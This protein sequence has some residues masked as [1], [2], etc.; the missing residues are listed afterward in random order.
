METCATHP[1]PKNDFSRA[2]V[3]SMNW[4]T[5]TKVPGG[6]SS[7]SDP[8]ADSETRSVTPARFMTSILAR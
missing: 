5:M 8:Q 7:R 6:R 4:S 2:K 3:R 1:V